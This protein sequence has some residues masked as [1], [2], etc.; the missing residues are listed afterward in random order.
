MAGYSGTP[1]AQKL[2]IK[3]GQRV[4]LFAPP[5]GFADWLAPLPAEV[6]LVVSPHRQCPVL[7]VFATTQAQLRQRFQR[8]IRL[9]P[10]DGGLWVGWPKQSS[11]IPTELSFTNVQRHGL[12]AGLVDNKTCAIDDDWSGARFVVR[13]VDRPGWPIPTARADREPRKAGRG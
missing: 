8:A 12:A 9:L 11:R 13:L 1:L 3:P 2:G 7:V 6:E 10:A 5:I 4:G